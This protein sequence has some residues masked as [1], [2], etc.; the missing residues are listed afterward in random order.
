MD[1]QKIKA[2]IIEDEFVIAEDIRLRLEDHGYEVMGIFD[3]AEVAL[4][5]ILEENPDIVLVDIKL[6]GAMNGIEMVKH[7]QVKMNLP[8]VYVTANS[9]TATYERAKA[10]RPNAF[11]I[12]PFTSANLLAS[13]DLALSN[14]AAGRIEEQIVRHISP[15]TE[16][17]DLLINQSLFVR[18]NGRYKKVH[19]DDIL[20]IEASGSYVHLQTTT[21][22]Y[23]LCQNL[24]QFQRKTPLASLLRIHRSFII[25][26]DNVDSFEESHVFVQK[27]KLPL[28][29]NFK[30]AFL[31]RIHLL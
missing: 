24:A 12:K 2:I 23:T 10:T 5:E 25:N 22:R 8:V 19:A 31:A 15:T 14:F 27:H 6:A 17:L 1:T 3:K 4:P 29:D 7:M 16:P 20:F 13:V 18:V 11:L 26:V 9:D 28:S 21:E 30:A